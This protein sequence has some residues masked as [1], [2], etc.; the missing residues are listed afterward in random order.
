MAGTCIDPN[1][2]PITSGSAARVIFEYIT[3]GSLGYSWTLYLKKSALTDYEVNDIMSLKASPTDNFF[4]AAL[5]HLSLNRV[6][7]MR[8]AS[9]ST[10]PTAIS[11]TVAL[12]TS[13]NHII[14]PDGMHNDGSNIIAVLT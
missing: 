10:S 5:K 8:I 6:V 1:L 12:D 2:C 4:V 13:D 9:S 11:N 14:E 7:F 3:T